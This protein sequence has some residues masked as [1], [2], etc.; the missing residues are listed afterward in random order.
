MFFLNSGS[1]LGMFT[2]QR[3]CS[4]PVHDEVVSIRS[5]LLRR[6][7]GSRGEALRGD[8]RGS[9]ERS[10]ATASR[11]HARIYTSHARA[12]ARTSPTQTLTNAPTSPNQ[13]CRLF[14]VFSH[15]PPPPLSA[16]QSPASA[17]RAGEVGGLL[18]LVSGKRLH[19][20]PCPLAYAMFPSVLFCT[21]FIS[22]THAK[23]YR[24]DS[25]AAGWGGGDESLWE[26]GRMV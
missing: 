15:T 21:I 10:A 17:L 14:C 4:G 11:T 6:E 5:V 12:L 13:P 22:T 18:S 9:V 3:S 26:L 8:Q 1:L 19:G 2:I 16:N 24:A 7:R 23:T 25:T 20:T